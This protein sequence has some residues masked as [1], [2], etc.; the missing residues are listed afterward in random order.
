MSYTVQYSNGA[1]LVVLDNTVNNSTSISLVGR[2]Y[3]SYGQILG[4]NFL[5]LLENFA[6]TSAPANPTAG[7]LWYN[8]S[9]AHLKVYTGSIFKNVTGV[10]SSPTANAPANPVSGDLWFDTTVQQ[11][12][13]WNGAA[14]III[15]PLVSST[16]VVSEVV[17][18][19]T[20]INY[21][22]ISFFINSS[23]WAIFSANTAVWTPDYSTGISGFTRGIGPGFNLIDDASLSGVK[24][25]GNS[26]N[27]LALG[28][29]DTTHYMRTD[30]NTSTNGTLSIFNAVG[31]I[32]GNVDTQRAQISNDTAVLNYDNQMA[33]GV[34]KFRT[35]NS[36]GTLLESMYIF[37]N[38]SALMNYDL[39]LVGNLNLV[40][41]NNNDVV[42]SGTHESTSTTSGALQVR[43][44]VG[45]SKNLNVGT[46]TLNVHN[47]SGNVNITGNTTISGSLLAG[48]LSVGNVTGTNL[49]GTLVTPAQTN[50]TSVGTLTSLN[51]ATGI[52]AASVTGTLQTA[53]QTNITSVG[54]LTSLSV[55]TG[56]I[57]TSGGLTVTGSPVSLG[58]NASVVITGGSSGTVLTTDG[59]GN[60]SWAPVIIPPSTKNSGIGQIAVYDSA[61]TTQG[62]TSLTFSGGTLSVTGAI[63]ATGD[64]IAFNTSDRRLKTNIEKITGALDKMD[65]ISGVTFDWIPEISLTDPLK[66]LREAGVIAQEIETVLPEVV[67]TRED[68]Y[69]AVRYEKLVPLLIEAI[70]ELKDRV[71]QLEKSQD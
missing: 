36:A 55:G 1:N 60:L 40:N 56:G 67:I 24:F 34:S 48:S 31:L 14:W 23:R 11:L 13:C 6:N 18:A 61:T 49:T 53:A 59:A 29:L 57:T 35:T 2:N 69:M 9:D 44:G 20:G 15:G 41:S 64:V 68:G 17:K 46:N 37:G 50:I 5:S 8:T 21:P 12:K 45:I 30:T 38:G 27:S 62:T 19:S 10:I 47:I 51:V 32:L 65:A 52:I 26:T 4:Q 70:K 54:T 42:I 22:V 58:S 3:P 28:G 25:N 16:Q 43:G 63:S 66:G 71:T 7:Q 39:N 33:N